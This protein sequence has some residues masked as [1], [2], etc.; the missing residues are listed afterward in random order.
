MLSDLLIKINNFK[1]L[2]FIK[3]NLN[4]KTFFVPGCMKRQR[5]VKPYQNHK[6]PS[7]FS[8]TKFMSWWILK[9]PLVWSTFLKNMPWKYE[10]NE[11]RIN[12]SRE[13]HLIYAMMKQRENYWVL[14]DAMLSLSTSCWN[15]WK[16]ISKE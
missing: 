11:Y 4:Y 2:N 10:I 5:D 14:N 9:I 3:R 16:K 7:I 15:T 6:W 13:K 1:I 12:D 8:R